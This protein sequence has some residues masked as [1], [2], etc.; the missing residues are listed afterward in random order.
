MAEVVFPVRVIKELGIEK[1]LISNAG[2][3]MNKAWHKG[4]LMLIEDHINLFGDNPLIG[5]NLDEYGPRFP[6]M[7]EPYSKKLIA[8]AEKTALEN[9]ISS[10]VSSHIKIV[11]SV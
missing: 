2:G 1:L 5:P 6:D 9:K 3:S 10:G 7:S 11:F 8:L 4:E